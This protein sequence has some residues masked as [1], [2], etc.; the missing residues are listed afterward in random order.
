MLKKLYIKNFALIRELEFYPQPGLNIITGETGAGKSIIINALGLILGQRADTE[1]LRHGENRLIVEGVIDSSEAIKCFLS[2]NELDDHGAEIIIR[3][4]ITDA[5]KNRAFINDSPVKLNTLQDL[6]DLLIDFHGQHAHQSLFKKELHLQILD[7]FAD[8]D[9][10]VYQDLY[11]TV[12]Q[13]AQ[14]LKQLRSAE[15]QKREELELSAY[16]YKEIAEVDP[17]SGEDEEIDRELTIMEGIEEYKNTAG[18]IESLVYG[19]E[20]GLLQSISK[21][22]IQFFRILKFKPDLEPFANDIESSAISLK[23]FADQS[24]LAAGNAEFDQERYNELSDRLNRLK[25]LKK[26]F[27]PTL[28]DVLLYYSKLQSMMDDGGDY[29]SRIYNLE[30]KHT[31]LYERLLKIAGEISAARK[32][33]AEKFCSLIN[34]EFTQLGL[35]SAALQVSFTENSQPEIEGM[36]KAEFFIRTNVGSVFAPLIKTASGGEISRVMLAIKTI[37]SQKEAVDILVFDEIDTGISGSVAEMVGA[38]MVS[39][40]KQK[41][42]FVITHLPVIASCGENHYRVE[43]QVVNQKTETRIKRLSQNE[44]VLEIAAMM[45]GQ[46]ALKSAE[47]GAIELLAK[48]LSV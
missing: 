24:I 20:V 9:L 35:K 40:A 19:D 17:R 26:K 2:E 22:K 23:E 25:L 33:A 21:L 32:S 48:G 41:Q 45:G 28:D 42:I 14:E 44:R 11:Q 31:M 27:G 18:I 37:I 7:R 13:T 47:A 36:E 38:K 10:T 1:F 15:K 46:T 12:Q 30:K 34:T 39:L 5:G 43:K 4:E 16:H 3:R 29:E 8:I 6:G